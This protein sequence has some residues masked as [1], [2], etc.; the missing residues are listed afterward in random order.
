[1]FWW[2][3]PNNVYVLNQTIILTLKNQNYHYNRI[4]RIQNAILNRNQ[5]AFIVLEY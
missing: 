1:M 4:H 2:I 3:V 5:I